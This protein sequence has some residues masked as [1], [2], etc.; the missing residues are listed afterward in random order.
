MQVAA[1]SQ[2]RVRAW[3]S[4]AR[5]AAA[6]FVATAVSAALDGMVSLTSQ[7]MIYLFAV[8]AAAYVLDRVAAIVCAVG[9]VTAFN[10]FF[11]P[12]RY[13]LTVEDRDNLIALAAML[14]VALL[15]STLSAA[16][17]RQTAAARASATRARQLRELAAG[18]IAADNGSDALRLGREAFA[19]AFA[20]PLFVAAARDGRLEGSEALPE[21]VQRGLA[22]CVAEAAV[23]GPGTGRWPG[24]DAWYVPLGRR[25]DVVGAARIEP[26]LAADTIGREHA[27]AIAALLAQGVARLRLVEANLAAR[28]A[29][30]RQHVQSTFLASVSHD[31]RTPLTA[32]VA[33]ASSLQQ[34]RGRLSTAEQDGMLAS[35]AS[36]A[37]YLGAVNENTLQLVRLS[38]GG[39]DLRL[40]WQSIEEIAGSV[41]ARLRARTGGG[42]IGVRIER[43]LPLVRGD[44]TLL[45][46]LVANL[47][48]NALKFSDGAVE[49]TACRA[50]DQVVVSVKD[51]G[52]GLAGDDARRVFEPFYRGEHAAAR[53]AGLGLALCQAIAAAHGATIGVSTRRHG[54]ARF[55]LA[56]PVEPQPRAVLAS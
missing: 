13:T 23:L 35:I 32:I 31:L 44:A 28:A 47:L 8:V 27:Q 53:G 16:L 41:V 49:L 54:G 9:A 38:A 52:P 55:T 17:K 4:V 10:F 2:E 12:P 19:H 26:A 14:A 3:R 20:G 15:V 40:E 51:R 11:V 43:E 6:L 34:Q 46:Q 5:V 21:E 24:L 39:V 22:C 29:L 30:E 56:M 1:T 48:D 37:S 25:G 7:A 50:G 36:E 33:A 18:L 42:R 45:A